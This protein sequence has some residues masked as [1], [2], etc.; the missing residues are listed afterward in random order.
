M[1]NAAKSRDTNDTLEASMAMIL[2]PSSHPDHDNSQLQW[3]VINKKMNTIIH[4]E[5]QNKERCLEEIL[6]PL[7]DQK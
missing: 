2:D 7:G 4:A 5:S 3:H 1:V 6:S